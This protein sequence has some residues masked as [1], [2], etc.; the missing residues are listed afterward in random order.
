MSIE[1]LDLFCGQ[2]G[3]TAGLQ[4]AGFRVTGVDRADHARRYPGTFVQA[5][6]LDYLAD[7]G[8][9]FQVIVAGPPCQGYSI[10]TAG[11]PEARAK[12][13]RLIGATRALLEATGRPWVIENVE[14]AASEMVA[15]VLLC[16]RMFGL[17]ADDLDG[18]RLVLER[19]RLFE[20]NVPLTAPPHPAHDGPAWVAGVYGGGRLAKRPHI[21]ATPSP[22]QDRH[23]AR[24]VRKGGYVPRSLAVR[25]AI[26]GGVD[27]MTAR[28][29]AES[30]P[31][32]Y[33]EHLGHQLARHL[34]E[35]A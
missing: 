29:L 23:E 17:E 34:R 27:W 13:P 28:G 15:P 30:I 20:S 33:A 25:Q 7:H 35:A 4:R 31:P 21:G 5:D 32:A 10:S 8:H 3:T 19:H 12:Y 1:A 2:G 11:N 9:R 26:M 16:G 6:A 22:R 18:Q 24:Y 14:Q